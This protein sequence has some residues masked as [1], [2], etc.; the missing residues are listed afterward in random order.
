MIKKSDTDAEF[1]AKCRDVDFSAESK[2][3]EKNLDVLKEKLLRNNE[4]EYVVL[5]TRKLK[6]PIA[7]AAALILVLSMSAFAFGEPVWRYLE[8]RIIQGEQYVHYFAA[9]EAA[10]YTS[11]IQM[12]IDPNAQGPIVVEIDGAIVLLQ[13]ASHFY[14]LETALSHLDIENPMFPAY[15]PEGFA[16]E[17][18][19][20]NVC[21]IRNPEHVLAA[22]DMRIQYSFG[23]QRLSLTIQYRPE[24]WGSFAWGFDLEEIT[25]NGHCG[26]YGNGMMSLHIGDV[27]YFLSGDEDADFDLL[28]RIMES[29]R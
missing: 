23:E 3:F 15:L 9:W 16:F 26:L 1:L 11:M 2:N 29:L 8:T 5:K 28:F 7:V 27:M 10:P 18:A 14:D 17:R 4:E 12:T 19:T 24:D 22:R 6:K 21:P 20:F 25:I 13:D